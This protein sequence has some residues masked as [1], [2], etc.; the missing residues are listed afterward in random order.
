MKKFNETKLF[1]YLKQNY[2]N[3]STFIK[4]NQFNNNKFISYFQ[5]FYDLFRL[6]SF[7]VIIIFSLI[8]VVFIFE[9]PKSISFDGTFANRIWDGA[10]RAIQR[11]FIVSFN[12][13]STIKLWQLN[14]LIIQ[15]V[16]TFLSFVLIRFF[17]LWM[18]NFLNTKSIDQNLKMINQSKWTWFKKMMSKISS[19]FPPYYFLFLWIIFLAILSAPV[20][21]Q[22]QLDF[23]SNL[24]WTFTTTTITQQGN[25]QTQNIFIYNYAPFYYLALF[26]III[27]LIL[28]LFIALKNFL[29]ISK[30]KEIKKFKNNKIIKPTKFRAEVDNIVENYDIEKFK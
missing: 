10:N 2:N 28:I 20:F 23:R 9:V 15:F 13:G 8:L 30:T 29:G 5:R 19:F 24:F 26:S 27:L 22:Y 12:I 11:T 1:Y 25:S 14:P 17:F 21:R 4:K 18:I 16:F 3:L 7:I 6:I